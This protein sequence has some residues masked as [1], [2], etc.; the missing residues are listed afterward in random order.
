MAAPVRDSS[1]AGNQPTTAN[2]EYDDNEWDIGIG[3]LIIDLDA[4]IEKTGVGEGMAAPKPGKMHSPVEH[5]ATVDKGLKMKIKRTKPGTKHEIVKSG[6]NGEKHANSAKRGSSSHKRDKKHG[7]KLTQK[8]VNGLVRCIEKMVY[9]VSSSSVKEKDPQGSGMKKVKPNMGAG[10]GGSG[11]SGSGNSGSG[12]NVSSSS[13]SS[14]VSSSSSSESSA[15]SGSASS[16]SNQQQQQQSQPSPP[17]QQST[18]S[19]SQQSAQSQQSS[20][21]QS[22]QQAQPSAPPAQSQQL[23][24]SQAGPQQQQQQQPQQ[25]PAQQQS[26]QPHRL[27][28]QVPGAALT[29]QPSNQSHLTAP[30]PLLPPMLQKSQPPKLM[31]PLLAPLDL[32]SHCLPSPPTLQVQ[33]TSQLPT[34][35]PTNT[36]PP[37][38]KDLVDVCVGT[39]VGTITEPDCLGPCE[40]GTSVTLEGIVWHET[41]GVLVVNVTWRGKTYVGTLLD[42]TRHDWAPP[43]FCDSPTSD[44]DL[45]TPKGRGKRGRSAAHSN[46]NDLSNFTETRSSVHSKLRSNNSSGPKG[47]RGPGAASPTPFAT[48]KS[49]TPGK[50]KTKTHEEEPPLKKKVPPSQPTSPLPPPVLLECP[51]PNCSKKYKH[52]NGLKYHQSHAHGS[53]DDDETKESGTSEEEVQSPM[54][55]IKKDEP[56]DIPPPNLC[57]EPV[58][59]PDEKTGIR[60]TDESSLRVNTVPTSPLTRAPTPPVLIPSPSED[61]QH[62]NVSLQPPIL[63]KVQQFKVKTTA[64]L[65]PDDK[66]PVASPPTS[67]NKNQ[68]Q[69]SKKKNNRKSPAGSPHPSPIEPPS[70]GIETGREEVQSPAYSDISDDAAPLLE[71]EVEGKPKTTGD[72]KDPGQSPQLQHFNM[73]PYYGQPPYLVPSVETKSKDQGSEKVDGKPVDKD[74]KEGNGEFSQ[75]MIQPHYYQYA[76]HLPGYS[77]NVD[78]Y[79]VVL[80]DKKEEKNIPTSDSKPITNNTLHIPNPSKPKTEM[81]IS[82]EKHQNE[83]HQILKESI[84]LKAQVNPGMLFQRQGQDVGRYYLYPDRKESG[85]TKATP[86]PPK[87]LPSPGPKHKE[88]TEEKKERREDEK[89][90]EGVKPTMETQGPPPPPTSQ[91]AYIHPGY[92]QSPHYGTLP[93]DP[94]HP[95]YRG[96]NPMLVSGYPNSPYLHPQ[97]HAVPRRER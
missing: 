49:D 19:L 81:G 54:P 96:M 62:I 91:Y 22:A 8:D 93:F 53:P 60:F 25:Q 32:P 33:V 1:S 40:P 11:N 24:Q 58:M 2:F 95:M 18:S 29:H 86:P 68:Q 26:S 77:Y 52:I 41:E 72:K 13:S 56:I 73:Y 70:L 97:L 10:S 42:C 7:D 59:E 46:L 38:H 83:N 48:P 9:P 65:M 78:S 51:E 80:D 4:D 89:K 21:Q 88:K 17:Q 16:S 76:Y 55:D 64:V 35:S 34:I 37:L 75:K 3:D 94:S 44:L 45:R 67:S 79:P 85:S 50:R 31:P 74:K 30:P 82:K 14:S 43:R 90:Q 39:S 47:R 63:T 92:M 61:E 57:E 6:E 66:K 5:Q 27:I 23:Q 15:V 12:N 28:A 84:E 69:S 36:P 87:T 20:A 71:S